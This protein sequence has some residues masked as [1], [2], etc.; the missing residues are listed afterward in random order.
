MPEQ[1]PSWATQIVAHWEN[2]AYVNV[3]LV[4]D[5]EFAD[6]VAEYGHPSHIV[7]RSEADGET[8]YHPE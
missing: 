3:T 2:G 4:K 6:L 8:E 5:D 7:V 1:L